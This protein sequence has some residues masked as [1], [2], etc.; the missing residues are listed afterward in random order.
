MSHN[1]PREPYPGSIISPDPSQ[2]DFS[3]AY[4]WKT[5]LAEVA[6]KMRFFVVQQHTVNEYASN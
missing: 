2:N 5:K 4:S 6:H 1:H 3:F